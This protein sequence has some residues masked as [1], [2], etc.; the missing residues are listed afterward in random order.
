MTLPPAQGTRERR[1]YPHG[2]IRTAVIL[3]I[4]DEILAGYTTDSNSHWLAE[5]FRRRGVRLLAKETLPDDPAV[6]AEAIR[7]RL[8]AGITD[9]VLVMGGL[10][11]TPDD[12]TYEAVAAAVDRPLELTPDNEAAIR[13]KATARGYA[14]EMLEDEE[15][16]LR[17]ARLPRGARAIPNEVGAAFG[18]WIDTGPGVVVVV[19]GVPREMKEM[20]EKHV[21]P[22][23]GDP[24]AVETVEEV[25]VRGLEARWYP[26]LKR[27]ERE[28]A[29]VRVGSYPQDDRGRI[30]LRVTGPADA[31]ARAVAE[32]KRDA[33]A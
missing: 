25:E 22:N 11:P 2:V 24:S 31:V 28:H 32:L 30:I 29:D 18:A 14:P 5:R 26:L 33:P 13:A 21:L 19:P 10:G 3:T 9:L 7:R 23:V 6:V 1:D 17:M 12:R 16:F 8:E 20:V 15:A 4:G 27:I